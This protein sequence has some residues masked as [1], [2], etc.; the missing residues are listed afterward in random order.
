MKQEAAAHLAPWLVVE[1][2]VL[3][4]MHPSHYTPNAWTSKATTRKAS[5]KLG[6]D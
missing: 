2:D 6:K 5:R 4:K 1:V 3:P